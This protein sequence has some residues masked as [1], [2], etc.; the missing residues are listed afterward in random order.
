MQVS[1]E[2]VQDVLEATVAQMAVEIARKQV[3]IV[4]LSEELRSALESSD[5]QVSGP[6][7][8]ERIDP[9]AI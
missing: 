1:S 4:H 3:L 9:G 2:T 7:D 5:T 8:K 6:T